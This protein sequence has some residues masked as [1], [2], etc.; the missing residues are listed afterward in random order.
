MSLHNYFHTLRHLKPVQIQNRLYRKIRRPLNTVCPSV[1]LAAVTGQ[2]QPCRLNQ[3]SLFED[4][5]ATFLNHNGAAN[6]WFAT[7]QEKLWMYNLHYFDDLTAVDANARQALHIKRIQSWVD[8]NPALKGDGW[9]PYPQSLRIVNWV[10]FALNGGEL[11]DAAI[12]SLALQAHILSQD[13]EY[14]ILGNHLF[15]N[16]KALCFAGCFF[17]G[18]AADKWLATGIKLLQKELPEQILADGGNFELTPMY[19]AIMLVDLLDLLNLF[20]CF[21]DRVE[22]ALPAMLGQYVDKML[23][24]LSVMSLGDDGISFFNDS[25]FSIAPANTLIRQYAQSLGFNVERKSDK[26]LSL[27]D[28]EASGYVCVK[29]ERLSFIADCAA[30]GPDYIPGHAHADSLSFE[31]SFR[32][33]R[34]FVNSGI[35][36]YGLGAE[37]LRQRQTPAHNTVSVNGLDSS[38]VWSGFRVARR[39]R[40]IERKLQVNEPELKIFSAGHDGFKQQ[41]VDCIHHRTFSV[42]PQ[43]FIIEDKLRGKFDSAISYWHLHPDVV[44]LSQEAGVVLLLVGAQKIK[45]NVEGGAVKI[46]N[47]SYHPSF[48][49]S[50]ENKQLQITFMQPYVRVEVSLL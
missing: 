19:H 10:K 38:E 47:G 37:R 26:K 36:Q 18:E 49:Q 25:A 21:N 28:L 22:A 40:I 23:H 31:M 45:V 13:L 7:G 9:E 34:I 24:L 17:S 2:W 48:G 14:H 12:Q 27:Y 8:G 35:D 4:G 42:T 20:I 6:D 50:L 3:A 32:G 43:G 1:A 41:G 11:N 16:A 46:M 33:Q 30:I 5:S 15:A 39:A 44:E 29:S